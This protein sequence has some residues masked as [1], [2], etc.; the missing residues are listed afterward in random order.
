MTAPRA[1][2]S[3]RRF[4]RATVEDDRRVWTRLGGAERRF[5]RFTAWHAAVGGELYRGYGCYSGQAF[6]TATVAR[7]VGR[8][9]AECRRHRWR[10]VVRWST[11]KAGPF[12]EYF[13]T[14]READAHATTIVEAKQADR[15][16]LAEGASYL[17]IDTGARLRPGRSH[18]VIPWRHRP[19]R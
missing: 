17:L 8:R 4:L 9:S 19:R 10:Y 6:K 12:F 13:R 18:E 3:Y 5:L 2:M 7:V 14:R 16:S 15:I 11:E 1:P